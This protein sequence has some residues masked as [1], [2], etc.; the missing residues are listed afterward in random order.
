MFDRHLNRSHRSTF[1]AH[2]PERAYVIPEGN[3]AALDDAVGFCSE[4]WNGVGA[5]V[6][7]ADV[8]GKI[9]PTCE[10]YIGTRFLDEAWLH[11]ALS[12]EAVEALRARGDLPT[13]DWNH[14]FGF[15]DPHPTD[16]ISRNSADVRW[17]MTVPQFSSA[18]TQRVAG[19]IW[20]GLGD[21]QRWADYFD[22]GVVHDGNAYLSLLGGQLG[23]NAFSPLKVSQLAM[24]IFGQ[25]GRRQ[26]WPCLWIFEDDASLEELVDFWNLRSGAD[27]RNRLASVVGLPA[28]ALSEPVQLDE[29]GQW[30]RATDGELS[31]TLFVK[32]APG[33]LAEIESVLGTYGVARRAEGSQP[34]VNQT[35]SASENSWMAWNPEPNGPIIRGAW[36]TVDYQIRDGMALITL[37]RPRPFR[38]LG[39]ARLVI[40]SIPTPLPITRSVGPKLGTGCFAHARGVGLNMATGSPW[41]LTLA[42]PSEAAAIQMWA[43]DY[44][45]TNT[46]PPPGKDARALLQRLGRLERLDSILDEVQLEI[47]VQLAPLAREQLARRLARNWAPEGETAQLAEEIRVK[48]RDEGLLIAL[49][50]RTLE[51]LGSALPRFEK[52]QILA[53]LAALV[54]ADFVVRGR[55]VQ[56]P[57]CHFDDFLA[58]R[59]LDERLGCRGCGLRYLLPVTAANQGEGQTAYRLDGLMARVLERHVL[60]V[61]LTLRSLRRPERGGSGLDHVWPGMLFSKPGEPDT[62]VDLLLSDG[63]RVLAAECKLDARSLGEDQLSKLLAFAGTVQAKPVIAALNG[64]FDRELR[65]QVI[66]D[67]GLVLERP[68]LLALSA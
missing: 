50:G 16:M 24:R 51:Q 21:A 45:Y 66:A 14:R 52:R 38:P 68:D 60:P 61:I 37:P 57:R 27:A 35:G 63:T 23:F 41:S 25:H 34:V 62:D 2:G 29:L 56:C 1:Y 3:L 49:D 59:D 19:V 31:P 43:A 20:G 7:I 53:G 44:G 30:T 26:P 67:D 36:D 58:L 65:E 9:L 33:R 5:L 11:P 32:A 39:G 12:A 48:L 10:R 55:N 6:L 46:E 17:Q 40:Q 4:V 8:D 64:E 54:E 18:E 47:L 15:P 42:L 28:S 22:L 13:C